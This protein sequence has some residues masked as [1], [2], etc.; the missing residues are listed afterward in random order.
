MGLHSTLLLRFAHIDVSTEFGVSTGSEF[1]LMFSTPPR[2]L[3]LLVTDI[4]NLA[5]SCF[6]KIAALFAKLQRLAHETS[7]QCIILRPRLEARESAA[8]ASVT[9]PN[10]TF[11]RR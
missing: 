10:R 7:R 1:A 11:R 6:L 8:A 3:N 5:S 9:E 4:E 2:T